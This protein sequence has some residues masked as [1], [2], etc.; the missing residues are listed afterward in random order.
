MTVASEVVFLLDVDNAR[1]DN[2]RIMGDD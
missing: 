1:H 2:D